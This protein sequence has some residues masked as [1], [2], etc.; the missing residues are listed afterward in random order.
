MIKE[1]SCTLSR[2][3]YMDNMARR[4]GE[5]SAPA[6]RVILLVAG[7]DRAGPGRMDNSYF[8]DGFSIIAQDSENR[9]K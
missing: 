9:F 7:G 6:W 3:L 4:A 5:G 1:N 8:L 2:G